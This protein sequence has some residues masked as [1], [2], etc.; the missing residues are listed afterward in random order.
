M[1]RQLKYTDTHK[2][3]TYNGHQI[4]ATARHH[5]GARFDA[6]WQVTQPDGK[7]LQ[8][9][10]ITGGAFDTEDQAFEAGRKAAREFIDQ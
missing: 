2:R 8:E 9:M 6:L 5:E 7:V 4:V 1:S 10:L 3:E